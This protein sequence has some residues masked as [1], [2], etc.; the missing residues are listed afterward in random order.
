MKITKFQINDWPCPSLTNQI[1][2]EKLLNIEMVQ[3]KYSKWIMGEI[4]KLYQ[5]L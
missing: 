5:L 1:F 3:K 2:N 4:H